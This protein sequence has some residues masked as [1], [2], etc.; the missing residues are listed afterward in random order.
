MHPCP[1]G[2]T[3]YLLVP[4]SKKLHI[5]CKREQATIT[6]EVVVAK[7]DEMLHTMFLRVLS[8]DGDALGLCIKFPNTAPLEPP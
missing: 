7:L 5:G 2:L 8:Y 6:T 4:N 3:R 1:W